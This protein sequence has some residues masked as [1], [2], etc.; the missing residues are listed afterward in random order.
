MTL[1]TSYLLLVTTRSSAII[2]T[3]ILAVLR[4]LD[5]A[6]TSNSMGEDVPPSGAS[7]EA[8]ELYLLKLFSALMNRNLNIITFFYVNNSSPL[9]SSMN[10]RLFSQLYT[11]EKSIN[12]GKVGFLLDSRWSSY[13]FLEIGALNK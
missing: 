11:E 2:L 4:A 6:N 7:L 12:R 5:S 1:Y 9:R 8:Y 3:N 10:I 13:Q